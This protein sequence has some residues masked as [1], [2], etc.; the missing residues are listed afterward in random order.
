[1]N[2]N[3]LM[4]G[5][6]KASSHLATCGPALAKNK[7]KGMP[8]PIPT[9]GGIMYMPG[10]GLRSKLRGA[11]TQLTLE[12]LEKRKARRFNLVDAQLNR[13]GGVKQSGAESALKALEYQDMIRKN[14]TIGLFG[15]STPW[16]K[17]KLR[18]GHVSCRDPNLRPMHVEGV[19]SDIM[20]REPGLIEFLSDDAVEQIPHGLGVFFN[21]QTLPE[22]AVP[23]GA[24][25]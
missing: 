4:I 23:S 11:L 25:R 20:R 18:V 22:F 8:T 16:V 9:Y 14:P 10:A 21:F 1:M 7:T 24:G 5:D 17:G 19:R 6:L 3:Y 2:S 15:A 13:V 12:A